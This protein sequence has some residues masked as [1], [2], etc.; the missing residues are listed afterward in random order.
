MGLLKHASFPVG[1]SC[2]KLSPPRADFKV[3]VDGKVFSKTR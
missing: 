3:I 1:L 2:P